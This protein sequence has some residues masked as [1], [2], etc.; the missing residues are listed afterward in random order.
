MAKTYSATDIQVLEGLDAVRMR[1]GMYI[2]STG[3][4]GLHHLIW[5]IVDNAI[6]EASNGFATEITVTLKKD[7]SCE[8]TDNGRGIP[9]DIHPQLGVSGVEVVY[10]QLHAG[11]KFNNKNYAYSGGLHGVGASVV[12]ALS[13]WVTVD[14]YRDYSHY[15]IRFE[16]YEDRKTGKIVSG[17]AVAPLEK[18][19]NT[20]KRGTQVCF[21]PDPRVFEDTHFNG[22]TVRRRVRELAYLNQGVRFVFTDEREKDETRRRREYCYEGGLADFVQYLNT[23]K[24]TITGPITFEGRREGTL[25]RVAIQYT[26]SYT[27]NIY[28][29]VNNVPTGEGGTHETGFKAAVTKAFNDYA[30]R[31]GLLKEKDNNLSGEDFREGMTAVVYAGVQKPQ[32]EGQTKGRLGNTEVRPIV[33]AI[34]LEQLSLYL[35]DLKNQ[36]VATRIV[37]KA[38][39]AAKVR[40]AARKARDV[41]RQKNQLEAAPLVGKLS[42]CTGRN[43]KENELFI[44]EGDSA[45]GS[46]KQGRDRRFQ[47]IL[48]LRGKPLNA[49]KKRI[50]QVLA[51]EEFRSIITALGT[52]IGEEFDLS[53]LKY[54]R[55]IILSD[56]DQDGAHIRAILLTFFFRYMRELVTDGHVYIGMPPLYCAKKGAEH[57]YCFDEK[58]LAKATKKLGRGYSVQR[59]KGLGEMNPE[60]L[61]ETT[62]NPNGRKMVQVTIEDL[63]EAERRVTVL[64]GDKV[65]PRREYIQEYANFNHVDDF[66]PVREGE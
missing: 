31:V 23:D 54:D 41:A 36:E 6:D 52:G 27:E 25:L 42:S 21:K 26:D 49:E 20:R 14:V 51:N 28:S 4:R 48:P 44:V 53:H 5:E 39:K 60:Q 24:Q 34:C 7:G 43:W 55:V 32:F 29:F 18:V 10:T 56:A 47:A 57:I 50:D 16:S 2:G 62:M 30:R 12:N 46:A 38:V 9:V 63:A 58:E 3:A 65:E 11:G 22:D 1:P 37:E 40:E 33:E 17:H 35:D 45:G 59:Y 8:V 61:W 64:M 66:E 15:H 19:G 13:E